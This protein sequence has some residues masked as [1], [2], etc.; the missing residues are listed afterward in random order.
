M[1]DSFVSGTVKNLSAIKN[2]PESPAAVCMPCSKGIS[3]NFS[4][5]SLLYY[6]Y[7]TPAIAAIFL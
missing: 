2:P 5:N 4:E 7:L 6:F 1:K 3:C